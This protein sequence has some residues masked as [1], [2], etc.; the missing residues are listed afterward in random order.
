M[1]N[2]IKLPPQIADKLSE[3]GDK[4]KN[5]DQQTIYYI[6]AGVLVGIFLLDYL[7]IM[8]PQIKTLTK[9]TPEINEMKGN[10]E[11]TGTNLLRLNDY[12]TQ[13]KELKDEIV[14]LNR[15]IG[16]KEEVPLLLE[17]IS[18]VAHE[19][20]IKIN[21]IMPRTNNQELILEK[22]EREYY[23][24][25]IL[26]EAKSTYHDL[27]R[28]LNDIENNEVYF[29]ADGILIS[30]GQSTKI[31]SIKLTLNAIVYEDK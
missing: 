14:D 20:G 4:L 15:S 31:N 30:R 29:E 26:I 1:A 23:S 10:V 25:P 24:L 21:Q 22:D 8:R 28:F 6:F 16:T 18:R 9:L 27:G 7:L 12:R 19:N 3:L 13:I 11:R 17:K 5:A 2:K